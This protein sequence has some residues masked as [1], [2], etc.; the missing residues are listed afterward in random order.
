MA[1]AP[2]AYEDA[3][4]SDGSIGETAGAILEEWRINVEQAQAAWELIRL[5]ESK[6]DPARA[7]RVIL[8]LMALDFR[9][10]HIAHLGAGPLEELL[11]YSGQCCIDVIGQ[12]AA[13]DPRF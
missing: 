2:E 7:L 6:Q 4:E 10:E 8:G 3:W 11:S 9:N 12:L 13:R 1:L 5:I